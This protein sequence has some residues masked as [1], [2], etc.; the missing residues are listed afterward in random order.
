MSYLTGRS[1]HS[2][3]LWIQLLF[4]MS[5]NVGSLAK[6]C[7]SYN[8]LLCTSKRS[9]G[10]VTVPAT[11]C[12]LL[13]CAVRAPVAADCDALEAPATTRVPQGDL[14]VAT[15]VQPRPG[16]TRQLVPVHP[17]GVPTAVPVSAPP[18]PALPQARY[19]PAQRTP[20]R[21]GTTDCCPPHL[22]KGKDDDDPHPAPR[23]HS[24]DD[25]P[26]QRRRHRRRSRARRPAGAAAHRSP[27]ARFLLRRRAQHPRR[28]R[29]RCPRGGADL[30]RPARDHP[31]RDLQ[32][33]LATLSRLHRTGH[34]AHRR[35]RRPARAD[36]H[37]PRAPGSRPG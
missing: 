36:R 14:A 30:L 31:P 13:E 37:R 18:R 27:R 33:Q 23:A 7:D 20:L 12:R 6:G 4:V 19:S 21:K 9:V 17:D 1:L 15:S 11:P 16:T 8:V 32:P 24:P 3:L 35:R 29:G 28:G 10:F 25:R 26:P 34:R 5:H 2:C 22:T